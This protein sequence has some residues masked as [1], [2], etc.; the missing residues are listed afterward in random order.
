[1][2]RG[3]QRPFKEWQCSGKL[4][5]DL[6]TFGLFITFKW[7][8]SLPPS[9]HTMHTEYLENFTLKFRCQENVMRPSLSNS[10]K[11]F[12]VQFWTIT[13]AKIY[14]NLS[15]YYDHLWLVLAF[16]QEITLWQFNRRAWKFISENRKI[17]CYPPEEK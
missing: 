2:N 7:F 14:R 4:K 1:M 6:R 13:I 17:I 8:L 9:K 3:V 16:V 11:T 5:S 15:Y 10:I 12:L